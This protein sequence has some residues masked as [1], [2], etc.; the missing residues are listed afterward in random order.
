MG[1]VL[2]ENLS[3]KNHLNF[4]CHDLLKRAARLYNDVDTTRLRAAWPPTL[5]GPFHRARRR[6]MQ[7]EMSYAGP[8]PDAFRKRCREA[9]RG[10]K[11]GGYRLA[12]YTLAGLVGDLIECD[13]AQERA[14][15]LDELARLIWRWSEGPDSG[16]VPDDDGVLA[17][18]ER[19]LPRC[20]ALVPRG[21]RHQ[22]LRGV[23]AHAFERKR[24]AQTGTWPAHTG[25]PFVLSG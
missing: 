1:A 8:C 21:S 19:E 5:S 6:A 2:F 16:P 3:P 15:K 13:S 18:F 4:S 23:Y 12:G 10:G 20:L 14:A 24:P 11:G 17:W 9:R 22:F 25:E 7:L